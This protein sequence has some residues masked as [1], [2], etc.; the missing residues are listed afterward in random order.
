MGSAVSGP[1]RWL[2]ARRP[3]IPQLPEDLARLE[4]ETDRPAFVD[5]TRPVTAVAAFPAG[6]VPD[7]V[8]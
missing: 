8:P 2:L 7:D 3:A 4:G 1:V 5:P 6:V